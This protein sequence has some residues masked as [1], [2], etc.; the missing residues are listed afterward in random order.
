[1]RADGGLLVSEEGATAYVRLHNSV[2]N[3]S[4]DV[5]IAV[6]AD[7][8]WQQA[9]RAAPAGV[10]VGGS[11]ATGWSVTLAPNASV[12]LYV[13]GGPP[14]VLRAVASNAS[15]EHWF[16]YQRQMQPLH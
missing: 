8:A 11:V 12:V 9:P 5:S 15:E 10:A 3:A 14:F 1:M 2:L 16:G 13:S 4:R 6:P 7:A